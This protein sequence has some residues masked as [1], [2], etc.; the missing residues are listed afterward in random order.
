MTHTGWTGGATLGARR[1]PSS[2]SGRPAGRVGAAAIALLCLGAC[3]LTA[4]AA[5][6]H[7]ATKG[8]RGCER[9]TGGK[10]AGPGP[11]AGVCEYLEGREGVVQVALFDK[12][13]GRAYRL[14]TGDDKQYTAS[15]VKVDILGRWLRRYQRS[16]AEIP[17]DIPYSIRY[18]MENMI[19]HSDN[20]AA[21][22]LFYFGGG[23][24]ALTRFNTL[25][26]MDDTKVACETSTYYGWGNTT[27]TAS[28]Q[29]NLMKAFAYGRD[30]RILSPDAQKYGLKLMGDIQPDQRFG[31]SCGPWG[32][33]CSPP[34]YANPDPDVDVALKNGWKTVPTCPL[35]IPQC[36]WQVN[37][38]GAV[39]GKGRDY[40]LT[41]LT[42]GDPAGV[43]PLDGYHYGIDTIQSVSLQVW[44]NLG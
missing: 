27:T 34:A 32:S 13:S 2:G 24:D 30:D 11:L 12:T 36:P 3:A 10:G 15:I 41:V 5:V 25:I 38:T 7:P 22:S 44:D 17:D 18:L 42:T 33:S 4:S 1:G 40:V 23:C 14:A 9:P 6:A 28:D 43:D 8:P 26:P 20:V 37:S 35:P 21:T 16:D 31:V 39:K 19:M 29:V